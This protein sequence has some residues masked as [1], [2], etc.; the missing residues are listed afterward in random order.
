MGFII[1]GDGKKYDGDLMQNTITIE[2]IGL[3]SS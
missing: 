1:Y 2:F 3:W